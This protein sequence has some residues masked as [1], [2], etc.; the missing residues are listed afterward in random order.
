MACADIHM[1]DGNRLQAFLAQAGLHERPIY[2][3]VLAAL[4]HR[5]K[6]AEQLGSLLRLD[7]E[8]RSLVEQERQRYEREGR[9]LDFPGW[10]PQQFE[11]EAGQREFSK[12]LAIQIAQALDAFAREQAVRGQD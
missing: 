1:L 6:D 3:H 2:G 5:L 12:I 11:T 10:S 4:Q 7:E 9:Q 8:I